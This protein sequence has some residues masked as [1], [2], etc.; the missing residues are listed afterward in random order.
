[1]SSGTDARAGVSARACLALRGGTDAGA[2][3]S[4]HA[5][6]PYSSTHAGACARF[7]LRGGA[8]ASADASPDDA[9]RT[10]PRAD[11]GS[12]ARTTRS[13]AYT[14]TQD[15]SRSDPGAHA[16]AGASARA[17]LAL[18]GGTR[19]GADTG[20]HVTLDASA[21]V[22]L[23]ADAGT[24]VPVRGG[25]YS[26]LDTAGQGRR[27]PHERCHQGQGNQGRPFL[28]IQSLH[29]LASLEQGKEWKR[30]ASAPDP[31][32]AGSCRSTP[33]L[34]SQIVLAPLLVGGGKLPP[35]RNRSNPCAGPDSLRQTR[36]RTR[37]QAA[38]SEDGSRKHQMPEDGG[39][40]RT[41]VAPRPEWGNP[42][43][44]SEGG[45]Q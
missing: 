20:A 33:R 43:S 36:G 18:R 13:G 14:S 26:Y 2:N 32:Q 40:G 8:E 39:V 37:E 35:N 11:A 19:A 22:S 1:A 23:G 12:D 6:S 29:Q 25:A 4:A 7:A 41:P 27:R 10:S 5:R 9:G 34:S 45:F 28:P 17:R 15:R 21:H 31:A 24:H 3:A 44:V 30:R 38:K 16:G 42:L